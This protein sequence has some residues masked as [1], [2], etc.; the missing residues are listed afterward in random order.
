MPLTLKVA[1]G[2][3]WIQ[4]LALLGLLA[5]F[6]W[7]VA[8]EPTPLGFYVGFFLLIF[9]L[10]WLFIVLAMGRRRAAA[11]GAVIALELLLL[12]P[13]YYMITGDRPGLGVA[14]GVVA[15]AV[16]GLLVAPPTNR[17]LT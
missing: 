5:I 17:A 2:L 10:A 1:I 9:T 8:R 13:A 16:I 12:A 4:F 11:R 7:Y 14:V 6:A 3:L 15:L